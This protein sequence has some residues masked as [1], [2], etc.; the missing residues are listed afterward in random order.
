MHC[1]PSWGRVNLPATL[2]GGRSGN[3]LKGY[4]LCK[5]S[6]N[7]TKSLYLRITLLPLLELATS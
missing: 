3:T 7:Q 5:Q 6:S 2:F 1:G 4:L